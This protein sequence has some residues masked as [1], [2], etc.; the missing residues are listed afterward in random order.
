MVE[1]DKFCTTY[2]PAKTI[3]NLPLIDKQRSELKNMA[4]A[5]QY[6]K[7]KGLGLNILFSGVFL[8]TCVHAADALAA[9]CGLKVKAFK[10]GDLETLCK[11]NELKDGVT[12]EKVKLIDYAFSQTTEEAHLLLI[13]DYNGVISWNETGKQ[14]DMENNLSVKTGVAALLNKLRDYRGLCCLIMPKCPTAH[15]PLE[16]HAHLK[17]EYPREEMQMQHWERNLSPNSPNND[18]DVVELVERYPMHIAEIDCILHRASIQSLIEG[19]PH[20]PSLQTVKSV[21]ERYRGKNRTPLL[22]GGK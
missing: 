12:H 2:A 13:V 11:D 5:F 22:F 20:T 4:Q 15:I 3:A 9:E 10:Y 8:E 18:N 14:N 1:N 19:K 16:F 7:Q 6:A 21:I 17:L